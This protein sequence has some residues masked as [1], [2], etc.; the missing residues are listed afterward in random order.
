MLDRLRTSSLDREQAWDEVYRAHSTE[1]H[2][3]LWCAGA[4]PHEI[5]DLTQRVF[6]VA[7]ERIDELRE[8]TSVG[9]WLR[10]I[11]LRVMSSHR[12]WRR[13]RR[14]KRW[15]L[16]DESPK[17]ATPEDAYVDD[18]SARRVRRVLE[19]LS[20]KLRDV[21]VLCDMGGVG[22]T[23][24]AEVLR[25]PLNTVR[26]RRRLAREEFARIWSEMGEAP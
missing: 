8:L 1:I 11:A 3:M 5:E 6:V 17:A 25:V 10:G 9:G 19:R 15:L 24:A 12:R 20:D 22:V 23:E 2:R 7:Y 21:L 4:T 14:L 13:V 18:E 26:S 16:G